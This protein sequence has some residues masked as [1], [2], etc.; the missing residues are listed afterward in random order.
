MN[1]VSTF[2]FFEEISLTTDDG[3]EYGNNGEMECPEPELRVL[4]LLDD[5]L[6][7]DEVG[8]AVDVGGKFGN[9]I[10]NLSKLIAIKSQQQASSCGELTCY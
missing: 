6:D 5:E 4:V 1:N 9:T 2:D 10:C 7:V 8:A 3:T